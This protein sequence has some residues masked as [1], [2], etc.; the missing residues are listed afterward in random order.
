MT[1]KNINEAIAL[2]IEKME[3]LRNVID[4]QVESS[5][6]SNSVKVETVDNGKFRN[7]KIHKT[8]DWLR[9]QAVFQES[10]PNYYK[11][12]HQNYANRLSQSEF[13][14]LLILKINRCYN[15]IAEQ[16]G[17]SRESVRVSVYRTRVKLGLKN[18]LELLSFLD[19]IRV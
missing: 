18:N 10:F 4:K 6:I 2:L 17:I 1:F 5:L 11:Y 16:L 9:F 7:F 19:S 13:R 3:Y 15:S 14:I 8:S 12:L